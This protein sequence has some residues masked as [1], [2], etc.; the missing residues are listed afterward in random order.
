MAGDI[1]AER[2]GVQGVIASDIID[3]LPLTFRKIAES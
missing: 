2:I 1:V 3:A